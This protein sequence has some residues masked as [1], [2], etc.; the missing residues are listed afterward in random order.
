MSDQLKTTKSRPVISRRKLL[1]AGIA[2]IGTAAISQLPACASSGSNKAQAKPLIAEKTTQYIPVQNKAQYILGAENTQLNP[3][4]AKSVPGITLNG[5]F[6]APEIRV[7]EGDLFRARVENKLPDQDTSIHW[8][9][10]LVPAGMDGVPNVS[11]VPIKPNEVFF[12]EY[13]LLQSGTYWYHSHVGFQEQ[14]GLGGPFIIEAADEP[15]HYDHDSVIFLSDWLHRNPYQVFDA[16]RSGKS[17][18]EKKPAGPDLADIKYAAFLMNGKANNAPWTYQAKPG[19]RIR[20]RIIN[21][22]A[23]T[24]FRLMLDDHPL[25]VTHADG[26]AVQQVEVDNML[27]GV[28]ECYDVLVTLKESGSFNLHA[29]AQDGSGQAIGILHTP[30]V[31]AKANLSKPLWGPRALSYSQLL[32]MEPTTLPDGP[33]RP[34]TIDLTGNM[35]KYIWSMNEQVYPNAEPLLFSHG[36]QVQITMPNKTPMWHPMHLHGHFFRL[37]I[38]GVDPR[39][40]PLKHTVSVPPKQSIRFEFTADNPGKWF[41]HCH[42]LYHLDAGM[43]REL[44]Y[45]V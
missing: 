31:K 9:G 3:D 5:Q 40:A 43:A 27:L 30:D 26:L 15:L 29:E 34:F 23:S 36:D 41:F 14:Q 45:R 7:K 21:G 33:L 37:L 1:K 18:V 22:A 38:P 8:H 24:F 2:G 16:L 17:S 35:K 28:G 6:P 20:L 11:H 32:S 19:E 4:G 42:N 39:F 12:Y 10:L 44:I 25:M 13:P